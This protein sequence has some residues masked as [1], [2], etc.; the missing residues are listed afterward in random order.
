MKPDYD[1]IIIGGGPAGATSACLLAQAGWRVAVIEKAIF[2]RPKVC[3]E[4][5]SATT[6]PLLRELG[7]GAPLLEMAGPPV[8]RVGVYAG[9][10]MITSDLIASAAREAPADGAEHAGCAIGREHLDALL[11]ARAGALGAEI[12]QPCTLSAFTTVDGGYECTIVAKQTRHYDTLRAPLVIAAHGSWESGVMPTQYL[13]RPALDSDLFGF[14]A[15]FQGSALPPDLMPLLAFPG[16]YGGM[17]HTDGNRVSLSC[18]IRRDALERCRR[19]WPQVKAG[20]AVLAHI[21]ASCKGV[22]QALS[23]ATLDGAWL[24]SGPLRP[25]IRTFGHEGIFAVGNAAAEAHPI[26]AEGISI[27]IQSATLLCR[28]LI[29]HPQARAGLARSGSV[30][31]VIREAYASAW[32]SNF[33]TRLHVAGVL[34]HLFMR[35]RSTRIAIGL[36]A[37]YP[38]LLTAGARWTGKSAPLQLASGVAATPCSASTP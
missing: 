27:A 3:G 19:T 25:G 11:L 26:I 21:V 6:W 2:P 18:C 10:A 13:R 4:Y 28:R 35:P 30:N 38:Q 23:P 29:S 31:Q 34:A 1:A 12:R 33:S 36:L 32:R 14:K 17:V 16:G 37:R 9:D 22:A 8:R 5:I 7:I 24:S 20:A 15:H